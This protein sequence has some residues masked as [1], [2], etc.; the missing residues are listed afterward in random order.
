MYV[1]GNL[2]SSKRSFFPAKI[3][4]GPHLVTQPG[5]GYVTAPTEREFMGLIIW[6]KREVISC[7]RRRYQFNWFAGG[8]WHGWAM[9][10]GLRQFSLSPLFGSKQIHNRVQ[11]SK[12]S[13]RMTTSANLKWFSIVRATRRQPGRRLPPWKWMKLSF[14]N[15]DISR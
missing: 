10:L 8:Q 1:M 2:F 9:G 6:L 4:H 15:K 5:T 12:S 13:L 11:N 7:R 3:V 14:Y